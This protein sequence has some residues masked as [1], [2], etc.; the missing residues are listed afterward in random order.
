MIFD[1][2]NGE[3]KFQPSNVE[4]QMRNGI[5]AMKIRERERKRAELQFFPCTTL[6]EEL[7]IVEI[8]CNTAIMT[9]FPGNA[10]NFLTHFKSV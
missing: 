10:M 4:R 5:I 8:V 2:T 1:L 3:V 7:K 9:E 6:I